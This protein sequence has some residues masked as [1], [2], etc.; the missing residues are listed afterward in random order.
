MAAFPGSARVIPAM[1]CYVGVGAAALLSGCDEKADSSVA[2]VQLGGKTFLL[3]IA[4]DEAKRHLGLGK[5]ES[6]EE[7]GGMLFVFPSSEN[8]VK[9]FVM[10]DCV[11][12]IDIIYLDGAGRILAMHNMKKEDPRGP[13][14]APDAKGFNT[15]Y[16]ERLKKYSSKYPTQFVI[17][18]KGGLL[19]SL[20]L[21]EGDIVKQK[22]DELKR[23]AQ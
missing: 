8:G 15:K 2:K 13:D 4:A 5:R 19:Q 6:I 18:I 7:D 14:E 1:V 21:K 9:S 23:V 10:R 16:D 20:N 22:W 3:E 12:D 17:E 11:I